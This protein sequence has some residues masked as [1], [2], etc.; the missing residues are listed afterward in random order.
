MSET[1]E[2]NARI[3]TDFQMQKLDRHLETIAI[4]R[5]EVGRRPEPTRESADLLYTLQL[6]VHKAAIVAEDISWTFARAVRTAG[7]A[8]PRRPKEDPASPWAKPGIVE[9]MQDWNERYGRPPTAEQWRLVD[10]KGRRPTVSQVLAVF[11]KWNDALDAA[12][13]S[14]RMGGR[15]N[16]EEQAA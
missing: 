13:F 9:A 4:L 1:P 11:P 15:S 5:A 8:A 2:Q 16:F 14:K 12:G 3:L 6:E 7:K 10:A